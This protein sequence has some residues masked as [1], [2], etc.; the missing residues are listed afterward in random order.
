[1]LVYFATLL[2]KIYQDILIYIAKN[3][4]IRFFIAPDRLI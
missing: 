2:L 4:F 3:R 1:M